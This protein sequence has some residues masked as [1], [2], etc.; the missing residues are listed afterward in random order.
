MNFPRVSLQHVNFPR[1]ELSKGESS[2]SQSKHAWRIHCGQRDIYLWIAD[3]HGGQ[4]S[5]LRTA[6]LFNKNTYKAQSFIDYTVV[7]ACNE[8]KF[9]SLDSLRTTD[10]FAYLF[11][12]FSIR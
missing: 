8:S 3:K 2:V 5:N 9:R 10:Q 1:E 4:A 6:D 7:M 11:F 12:V